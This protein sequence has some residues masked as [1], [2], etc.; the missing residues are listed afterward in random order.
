MKLHIAP[1]LELP[2]DA[3]T[4]TFGI[5]AMRGAGK[6]NLARVMAEEMFAARL[7]FVAVDPVAI[8]PDTAPGI[9]PPST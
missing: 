6:T 8:W 7:P 2:L 3:V 5:L 1:D 9:V 4:Q